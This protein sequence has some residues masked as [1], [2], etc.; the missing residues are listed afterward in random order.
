LHGRLIGLTCL[1][2]NQNLQ[3]MQLMHSTHVPTPKRLAACLVR[4]Q[5]RECAPLAVAVARVRQ[6]GCGAQHER[7]QGC[8]NGNPNN[9]FGRADLQH[10]EKPPATHKPCHHTRTTTSICTSA[11]AYC[12]NTSACSCTHAL[13]PLAPTFAVSSSPAR[14]RSSAQVAP[15]GTATNRR[16]SAP[17]W[18]CSGPADPK[19]RKL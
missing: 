2:S 6:Q 5:L 19:V 11:S 12:T 13:V 8:A 16:S 18:N 10:V 7:L 1:R 14:M 3:S 9:H 17:G 15:A 4:R